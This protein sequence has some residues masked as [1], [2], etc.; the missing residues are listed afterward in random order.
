MAPVTRRQEP[1]V[2]LPDLVTSDTESDSD[3][4]CENNNRDVF[5]LPPPDEVTAR[6]FPRVANLVAMFTL[7][8][9][10]RAP[11][12]VPHCDMIVDMRNTVEQHPSTIEHLRRVQD[13]TP[14]DILYDA[15]WRFS[16]AEVIELERNACTHT[17]N[18]CTIDIN[19]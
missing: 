6:D 3:E 14:H 16:V 2:A 18:A 4:A 11:D 1:N 17:R 10:M 19:D 12:D 7:T 5:Q 15:T 13:L 8:Q 9:Q